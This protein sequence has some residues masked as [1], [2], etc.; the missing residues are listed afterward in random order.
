MGE[1]HTMCHQS[2]TLQKYCS[3]VFFGKNYNE[4]NL[5]LRMMAS[6][7]WLRTVDQN[8]LLRLCHYECHSSKAVKENTKISTRYGNIDSLLGEVAFD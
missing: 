2:D 5:L 1:S 7:H 6:R 3:F 4:S 8:W